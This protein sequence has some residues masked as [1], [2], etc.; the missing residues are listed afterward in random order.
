MSKFTS[1][2]RKRLNEWGWVVLN[3][4]KEKDLLKAKEALG[5][6]EV[7]VRPWHTW[8]DI[9]YYWFKDDK[10]RD[11]IFKGLDERGVYEVISSP[12]PIRVIEPEGF[13]VQAKKEGEDFYHS[14]SSKKLTNG[15]DMLLPEKTDYKFISVTTHPLRFTS[16]MSTIAPVFG[17]TEPHVFKI[18]ER[19]KLKFK[20]VIYR[21]SESRLEEMKES[22]LKGKY[23]VLSSEEVKKQYGKDWYK[24]VEASDFIDENEWRTFEPI[25]VKYLGNVY[26]LYNILRPRRIVLYD[27]W[28]VASW[29]RDV[30]A[31][32]LSQAERETCRKALLAFNKYFQR[33]WTW[34]EVDKEAKNVGEKGIRG[35]SKYGALLAL[36]R[37]QFGKETA[38]MVGRATFY[39]PRPEQLK[40]G[41]G[42][43]QKQKIPK[44]VNYV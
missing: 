12:K 30:E 17:I 24:Y 2:H 3:S 35:Y 32:Y 1:I 11:L 15:Y 20:P 18:N 23:N 42:L 38:E 9:D 34:R 10:R 29:K 14:S 4:P 8:K 28:E 7:I 5:E 22:L 37:R 40:S 19:D 31:E 41:V 36:V 43:V 21:V 44:G 27:K 26:K 16:P 13:F 25:K 6:P 33:E 39:E